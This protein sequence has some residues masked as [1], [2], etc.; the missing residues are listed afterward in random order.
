MFDDLMIMPG[1]KVSIFFLGRRSGKLECCD[2]FSQF[3]SLKTAWCLVY[4]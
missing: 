1:C 3:S 4:N 2:C